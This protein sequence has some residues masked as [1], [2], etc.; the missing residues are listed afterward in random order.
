MRP[1][2]GSRGVRR[3]RR[4]AI[5][6][7][8]AL[9]IP[10]VSLIVFAVIDFSRAYTQL[11]ALNSALREGGR[12]GGHLQDYTVDYQKIVKDAIKGYANQFG[13]TAMDT[14]LVTVAWN[15]TPPEFITVT[16]T[17]HPI[18]LQILGR[19]LGVPPLSVS[20]T[21]VYR[22]ECAGIPLRSCR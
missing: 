14:S 8:F 12:I 5:I 15:T 3:A 16:A 18:P 17:N 22:W 9:V 6:V 4:G 7:E 19:F 2:W 20:R 13:F 10:F 1:L 11:N 21:V